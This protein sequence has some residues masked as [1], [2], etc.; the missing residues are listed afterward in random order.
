MLYALLPAP[1]RGATP[2]E[3]DATEM[4]NLREDGVLR[5][6]PRQVWGGVGRLLDS[7]G[8]LR[9]FFPHCLAVAA[10]VLLFRLKREGFSRCSVEAS[11]EGLLVRGSR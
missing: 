9:M 3:A 10:P 2:L 1:G 8:E 5:C 7:R 4:G 6:A 11:P